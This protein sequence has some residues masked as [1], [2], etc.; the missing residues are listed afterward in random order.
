MVNQRSVTIRAFDVNR[1]TPEETRALYML[2]YGPRGLRTEEWPDDPPRPFERWVNGLRTIPPFV[3]LRIWVAWQGAAAV[4]RSTL[5]VYDMPKNRHIANADVGV[6]IDHRRHGIGTRLV[7][8]LAEAAEAAEKT[9]LLTGTDSAIPAGRAFTERLGARQGIVDRTNQLIVEE[10]DPV[11]MKTWRDQGPRAE[12]EL[13]W[14]EGAYPESEIDA[15]C[16]LMAVMN[17]APRDDLEIEDQEWTPEIVRQGEDSMR[18]RSIQRSTL[19]ARHRASGELAGYTEVF[20]DPAK[21]HVLQQGDT[22]VL[23]KHRG[24][25]LGKWLKATMVERLP[26]DWPDVR[27]MRTDNANSNA[28]M[29][30]INDAMGFR[31]YKEWTIWQVEVARVKAYLSGQ[32]HSP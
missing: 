28:P 4:G 30:K 7:V 27:F 22:G 8:P 6:V 19:Y 16:D 13:G 21:S 11:L 18:Q 15:V 32:Y 20:Y 26:R 12:Y 29:L 9:L 3:T 31:P 5:E 23:P 1:A 14:W 25:G 17:T 2:L 24:H 10:L